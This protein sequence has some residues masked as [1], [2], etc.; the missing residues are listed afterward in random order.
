MLKKILLFSLLGLMYMFSTENINAQSE[1]DKRKA[2]L[3][4]ESFCQE[5]YS[6]CFS[7]RTYTENTLSVEKIEQTSLTQIKV[8][9]YHTYKGRFGANYPKMQYYAYIK[10][11]SNSSFEI[12]F[13]KHSKADAF[14]PEDYWEVCT[15]TL[16]VK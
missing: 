3:I 6:S 4:L 9:G 16:Y 15:K 14:H 11:N 8:E 5:F 1:D 12:R 10:F 2:K 13:H 7:G